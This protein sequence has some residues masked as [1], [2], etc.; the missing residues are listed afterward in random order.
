MHL[1]NDKFKIHGVRE[2][3]LGLKTMIESEEVKRNPQI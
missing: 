1:F 3:R 2:R